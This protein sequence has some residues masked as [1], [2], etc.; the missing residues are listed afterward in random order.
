MAIKVKKLP[1]PDFLLSKENCHIELNKIGITE[2]GEPKA[3]LKKEAK[4]IFSEK[5]KRIVTP[6]GVRID[7][8]GK[9]IIKGDIAPDLV[10]IAGGTI[11]IDNKI[12]DIYSA[13]RPRNPD[14]TI[15]H[16]LFE[17]M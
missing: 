7:L 11:K 8:T 14:E 4:Y 10:K 1:F 5:T 6:D 15:H 9:V 17:V 12:L 2:E 13:A 16:T 3:L